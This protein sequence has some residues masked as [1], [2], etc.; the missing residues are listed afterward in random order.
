MAYR[1]NFTIKNERNNKISNF[2]NRLDQNLLSDLS[3]INSNYSSNNLM[4]SYKFQNSNYPTDFNNYDQEEEFS[5]FFSNESNEEDE[6]TKHQ[7]DLNHLNHFDKKDV[8]LKLERKKRKELENKL[9]Q[10]QATMKLKQFHENEKLCKKL[11]NKLTNSLQNRRFEGDGSED[12]EDLNHAQQ[13]TKT[14]SKNK[15]NYQSTN[16]YQNNYRTSNSFQT[17]QNNHLNEYSSNNLKFKDIDKLIKIIN[18][19]Q[20]EAELNNLNGQ[21]KKNS[22][23]ED[24]SL[25]NLNNINNSQSNQA[26]QTNLDYTAASNQLNNNNDFYFNES[27]LKKQIISSMKCN[28][29]SMIQFIQNQSFSQDNFM[30][31]QQLINLIMMQN[32]QFMNHQ[33]VLLC[34]LQKLQFQLLRSPSYSSYSSYSS[35]ATTTNTANNN[36]L[37]NHQQQPNEATGDNSFADTQLNDQLNCTNQQLNNNNLNA[38]LTSTLNNQIESSIKNNFF[39]NLKSHSLYHNQLNTRLKN[40]TA[41]VQNFS[42]SNNK[43]NNNSSSASKSANKIS[44]DKLQNLRA[45]NEFKELYS[46]F[47]KIIEQD[48]Q[49]D[50]QSATG[51]LSNYHH[52][53]FDELAGA[54]GGEEPKIELNSTDLNDNLHTS[55]NLKHQSTSSTN[56]LVN[57]SNLNSANGN[58]SVNHLTNNINN[59]NATVNQTVNNCSNSSSTTNKSPQINLHLPNTSNAVRKK[60]TTTANPQ[61]NR[62]NNNSSNSDVIESINCSDDLIIKTESIR[63]LMAAEGRSSEL[64][65]FNTATAILQNQVKVINS[66]NT[67]S[68]SSISSTSSIANSSSIVVAPASSS[69]NSAHV[70][71]KRPPTTGAISATTRRNFDEDT[72]E[73]S[74]DELAISN[75]NQTPEINSSENEATVNSS[76]SSLPNVNQNSVPFVV[77]SSSGSKIDSEQQIDEQLG[78]G[79]HAHLNGRNETEIRLS[80]DGEQGL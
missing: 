55:N 9:K 35:N 70:L 4:D 54:V 19:K 51:K 40:S 45:S 3:S 24:S 22:L 77:E 46:L 20:Q 41:A 56:N 1:N 50:K 16:S 31:I 75:Q 23:N 58:A 44:I 34:W 71:I 7:T 53:E 66:S 15:F 64:S 76:S 37:L 39:D 69:N 8:L 43:L 42:S 57:N 30:T 63:P 2:M 47:E 68:K 36:N 38:K 13:T 21:M 18:F 6:D 29:N 48:K 67:T 79:N 5:N 52:Q 10:L 28:F 49:V 60:T 33:Q 25:N 17:A 73:T 62:K 74:D 59:I 32:C 72:E 11:S 12:D 61:T 26:N 14:I 65:S 78:F 80:G 27:N